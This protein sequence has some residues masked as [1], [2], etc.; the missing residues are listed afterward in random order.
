MNKKTAYR[1]TLRASMYTPDDI[2]ALE[3][4]TEQEE[5]TPNCECSDHCLDLELVI[6]LAVC[7]WA[8]FCLRVCLSRYV[9]SLFSILGR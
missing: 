4:A 9:L 2:Q 8:S 7:A 1:E 5:T 6:A 3:Q